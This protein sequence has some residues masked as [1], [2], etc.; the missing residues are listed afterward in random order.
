VNIFKTVAE[1]ETPHP[2]T[3]YFSKKGHDFQGLLIERDVNQ[4][5]P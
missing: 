2:S 5:K 4:E 1:V 3:P